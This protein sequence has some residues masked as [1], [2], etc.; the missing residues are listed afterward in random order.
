MALEAGY[1]GEHLLSAVEEPT[2]PG[3]GGVKPE[4]VAA[5]ATTAA[6]AAERDL[7][8][9]AFRLSLKD[10]FAA[11]MSGARRSRSPVPP[12]D[13]EGPSE[14]VETGRA[15]G[16]IASSSKVSP[17]LGFRCLGSRAPVSPLK[18]CAHAADTGSAKTGHCSCSLLKL[19][20]EHSRA[21]SV[22]MQSG[23]N[24]SWVLK[25]LD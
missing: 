9:A 11:A 21:E 14:K 2:P 16:S 20:T 17:C 6:T 1:Q 3:N 8:N 22:I 18:C 7:N 25:H 15:A 5:D 23:R 24:L 10:R 19:M 13:P 4:A 12:A